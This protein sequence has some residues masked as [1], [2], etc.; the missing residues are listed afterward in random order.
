MF[1]R[2]KAV[3]EKWQSLK[4]VDSLTERDLDDLGMTRDQVYRFIRMPADIGDRV[5]H[6]AAIFGLSEADVQKDH[7]SYVEIL[8]RCG[9]CTD[10]AACSKVLALGDA[11][12]PEQCDFCRNA[13][14][15]A[16]AA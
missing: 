3:A 5:K 14:T 11:A 9:T 16:S 15:F 1:E 12:R 7:T 10:R 4:E 13:R 8:E 2:I 6:M